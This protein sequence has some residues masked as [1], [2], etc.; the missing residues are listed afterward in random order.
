M[1]KNNLALRQF[2]WLVQMTSQHLAIRT[3]YHTQRMTI[4]SFLVITS[5]YTRHTSS[6]S[7]NEMYCMTRPT[8]RGITIEDRLF[9]FED[10][11][12]NRYFHIW[13]YFLKKKHRSVYHLVTWNIPLTII[14]NLSYSW[15][16]LNDNEKRYRRLKNYLVIEKKYELR[17]IMCSCHTEC[18]HDA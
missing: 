7:I 3:K 9:S 18:F 14:F 1:W 2:L 13:S 6:V 11:N 5:S 8:H 16:P 4:F 12:Q 17:D 10:M 15:V